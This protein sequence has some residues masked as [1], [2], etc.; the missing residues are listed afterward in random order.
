L[1]RKL[2]EG[3]RAGFEGSLVWDG[4]TDD[5]LRNRVG[6]YIVLLEAYNSANGKNLSFKE[7]VVIAR[8]F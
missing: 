3:Q 1:V 7:T 6:I 8:K 4:K 2:A 5:G